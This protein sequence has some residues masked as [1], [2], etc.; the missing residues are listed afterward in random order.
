MSVITLNISAKVNEPPTS[1]WSSVPLDYNELYVFSVADFTTNTNPPYSDPEGDALENV[2]IVTLPTQG[3]LNLSAVPVTPGQNITEN[4]IALGN[5]TYQADV[6]ATAGYTDTAMTFSVS[7][8]GSSTFSSTNPLSFIV[9]AQANQPP[10]EVGDGT[11]TI[12]YG[13]TL[14]FTSAMFTSGTTPP[15]ADPEG[16]PA[17][18][19]KILTLP[20]LGKIKYNGVNIFAGDV[21][22]LSDV[23]LGLLTYVP[24]NADTDGDVQGFTF[25]V[26]DT[27]S[28]TYTS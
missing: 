7:D 28:Q 24:D 21:I 26:S 20:T 11:A 14:V 4:N 15:Y 22:A 5:L 19:L 18:N 8:V 27:G 23:D 1:G 9:D 12:P 10:S 6:A 13:T 3:V 25:Q 2:K 16:D 17:S